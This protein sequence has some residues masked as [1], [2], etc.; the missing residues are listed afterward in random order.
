MNLH[1][2]AQLSTGV[3]YC[4]VMN[5]SH[6]LPQCPDCGPQPTN[7]WTEFVLLPYL[8]GAT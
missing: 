7:K 8:N 4:G 3:L 6:P 1:Q 5:K 2:H